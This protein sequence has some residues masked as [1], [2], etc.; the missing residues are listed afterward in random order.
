MMTYQEAM[1]YIDSVEWKGSRPG[2]ER[3]TELCRM[4][5]DPQREL[6]FIHIAGTNGKGSVSAMLDAVLRAA[7]CRVGLFTS[8]YIERF[9]DRIRFGGEDIPDDELARATEQVKICAEAM[10]DGPTAFELITAIAL[11]YFRRMECDYVVWEVG[12]G[13]RLDATNVADAEHVALSI[14]TGVAL[15]HC[16]VLG[17]T[18][19]AIAG[20]KAGIIKPGVPVLFGEADADAEAVIRRTA[21]ERRCACTRTD[22]AA[23]SDVRPDLFGTDFRFGGRSVRI[24]LVGLYQTRN[25]ATVLTAVELLRQ[26]G[27]A[28]PEEAVDAGL[29]AVRWKARFEV[30][31]RADPLVVYDGAHNPHGIGG[32]LENVRALLQPLTP[33]GKLVLLMGVM[34]D[35]DHGAMA[36]A[37]APYAAAAVTVRPDDSDRALAA[38]RLAEE[39]RSRGVSA[40]AKRSIRS[41]VRAA[42]E[43]AARENRPLLCLGSLYMYGAVKRAVQRAE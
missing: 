33:D 15:D 13:G 23:I 14:I 39:F 5:R 17:S 9:N 8:P 38:G 4:L 35:K 40:R 6:R 7:G 31:R 34:A 26:R 11:V 16:Y 1:A 30:L 43:L 42:M 20:E 10:E 37:L 19:A 3:I 28:I 18:T 36:D 29:A 22:F 41:G 24:P 2:L 25:T 12:M 32:A 27:L 21:A